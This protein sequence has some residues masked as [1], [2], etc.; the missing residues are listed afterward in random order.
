MEQGDAKHQSGDE[1]DGDLQS[2]MRQMD[3]QQEPAARERSQQH[4]Q[5]INTQQFNRSHKFNCKSF[6]IRTEAQIERKNYFREEFFRWQREQTPKN[7]N[8]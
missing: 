2:R 6:A 3:E 1:A 4:Q 5:T 7:S 8:L